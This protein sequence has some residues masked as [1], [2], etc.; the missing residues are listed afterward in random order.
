MIDQ[1]R[2]FAVGDLH[3]PGGQ[4]KPM[5][6]FGP[7]WEFGF[8]KISADWRSRVA[9]QDIV[10]IPGD[11]SWAMQLKD[12]L[13]DLKAISDLPGQKILLKGNHDYWWN[14]IGTLRRHLPEGMFA[15]QYDAMI[16]GDKVF[17]GTRGWQR[18][19]DENDEEDNRLYQRELLRLE[20]SLQKARE[21]APEK[22][23][24]ALLHYPPAD[25]SGAQTPVTSLLERYAVRNAVYGHLHGEACSRGIRGEYRGVRYHLS[26]CDCL[27]FRLC[28]LP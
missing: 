18:P 27:G 7:E 12:A 21:I 22:E 9:P 10:L 19:N 16:L 28:E 15:L 8:E 4:E 3:L 2:V 26:S 5:S 25:E 24:I 1:A 23:L 11:I 6:I 14:G 20:L 17:C 13:A